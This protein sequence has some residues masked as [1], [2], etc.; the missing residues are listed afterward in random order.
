MTTNARERHIRVDVRRYDIALISLGADS[1]L[2][3]AVHVRDLQATPAQAL[4][5]MGP[6]DVCVTSDNNVEIV[7][8]PY[9]KHSD[10]ARVLEKLRLASGIR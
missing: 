4:A 3:V 6:T 1:V 7:T 10:A 8:L 9:K 2:R 5:A